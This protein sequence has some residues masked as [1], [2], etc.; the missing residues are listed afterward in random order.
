MP[1]LETLE[2]TL[3]GKKIS[4]Q[5]A[6]HKRLIDVLREDLDLK[7]TKEGCGEGECGAC[8]VLLNGEPVNS[9]LVM[10]LQANECTVETIEGVGSEEEPHPLQQ[11]FIEEGAVQCGYCT[12]GMILSAKAFLEKNPNPT[13]DQIKVAMSGNICRCTGYKKIIDAVASAAKKGGSASAR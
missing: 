13:R 10:A 9:C 8:T 2:M 1:K 11:A 6:T 4:L 12:P 3:N 5:V 7:G